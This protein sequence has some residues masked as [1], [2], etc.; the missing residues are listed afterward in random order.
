MT[1]SEL[2]KYSSRWLLN[3]NIVRVTLE[4]F[5]A[6]NNGEIPDVIGF[7]RFGN[8]VVIECKVSRSDFLRDHKKPFRKE[9]GMGKYR[10]FSC[11]W[12]LIN[13]NELP[14]KWGLVWFNE[15]GYGRIQKRVFP[16]RPMDEN[17]NAFYQNLLCEHH[18]MMNALNRLR[19]RGVLDRVY[20]PL[21]NMLAYNGG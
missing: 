15:N 11:P 13:I 18:L 14:E 10:L 4:E 21:P 17:E 19:Y 12:G 20:E 2:V 6:G 8:S 16:K 7:G 3:Q 9:N 5:G 1:H